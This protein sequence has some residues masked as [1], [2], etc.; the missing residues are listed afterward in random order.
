MYRKKDY[1]SYELV[2]FLF[3]P[4]RSSA[5]V[6][7]QLGGITVYV[8]EIIWRRVFLLLLFSSLLLLL[9]LLLRLSISV[10]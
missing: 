2:L 9:F 3:H 10:L 6:L 5:S 1:F 7:Q 4:Y 8:H